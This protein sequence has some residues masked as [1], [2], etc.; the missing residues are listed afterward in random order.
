[1]IITITF[2]IRFEFK[3]LFRFGFADQKCEIVGTF[4]H[5]YIYVESVT[6]YGGNFECGN[7]AL[8]Y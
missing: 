5:P 3:I 1:M 7:E 6:P 2:F 4:C 8:D